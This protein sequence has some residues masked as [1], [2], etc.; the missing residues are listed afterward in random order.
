MHNTT[1][2]GSDPIL[3]LDFLLQFVEEVNGF[4]RNY[5][6]GSL[7]VPNYLERSA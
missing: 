2:S 7:I 1:L 5:G 3:A 6:Q 4:G